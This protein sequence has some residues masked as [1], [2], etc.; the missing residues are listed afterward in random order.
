MNTI[1]PVLILRCFKELGIARLGHPSSERL[2]QN[3]P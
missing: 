1:Y 2:F 3:L